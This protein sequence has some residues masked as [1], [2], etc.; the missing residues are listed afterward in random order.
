MMTTEAPSL[1]LRP[2]PDV[3]QLLLQ[4]MEMR[5]I[6]IAG[7]DTT[8]TEQAAMPLFRA[9]HVPVLGEWFTEPLMA[10]SGVDRVGEATEHILHPL[11][12]RLLSRCDAVL[13]VGGPCASAD[14]IVRLGRQRG[15]R[16]FF[17]LKEAL[18]G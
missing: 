9:G 2:R 13:R 6:F 7:A 11:T 8:S 3:D 12:D 1:S 16:V 10:L 18:V 15:L 17:S 5:M 14:A 4:P